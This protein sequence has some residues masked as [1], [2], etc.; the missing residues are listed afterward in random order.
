MSLYGFWQLYGKFVV[1]ENTAKLMV[2]ILEMIASAA[3]IT[4]LI[5][6]KS[7]EKDFQLALVVSIAMVLTDKL[8]KSDA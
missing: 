8:W 5:I 6:E 3:F 4:Y 2:I 1:K 7:F